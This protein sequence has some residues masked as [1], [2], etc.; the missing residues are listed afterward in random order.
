MALPRQPCADVAPA[1]WQGT[2]VVPPTDA[3]VIVVRPPQRSATVALLR[4][5]CAD[6]A[7]AQWQGTTVVP[8]TYPCAVVPRPSGQSAAVAPPK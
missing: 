3:C 5:P 6:V 7:I 2:T 8:L 4:Q 1:Q